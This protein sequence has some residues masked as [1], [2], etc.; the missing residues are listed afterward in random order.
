MM[1]YLLI[2]WL[3]ILSATILFG[4]GIGSAFYLLFA[5]LTRDLHATAVVTRLVVWADWC[6][7]APA[8]ILQP[9]TGFYMV[10]MAGIPLQTKWVI[11][12]TILYG[13]AIACWLPVV[14]IQIKMRN[15][16][17]E[18]VHHAFSL[19]TAY[20]RYLA[21]WVLLG[22]PAFIAFIWVFYLMVY[23]SS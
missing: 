8:V 10:H 7:T 21:A 1:E 22:I 2:K 17:S 11:W 12:S 18:A 9:L 20:W 13:I 6:F 14:W 4:A 19:P 23:K 3:H 5:S 16:A 15:L